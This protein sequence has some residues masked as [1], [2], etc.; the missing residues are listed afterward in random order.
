MKIITS[1]A[2]GLSIACGG[3]I[4]VPGAGDPTFSVAD[5]AL[6]PAFQVAA[7]RLAAATGVRAWDLRDT[8]SVPIESVEVPSPKH[9]TYIGYYTGSSIRIQTGLE[10]CLVAPVLLHEI[11]HAFGAGHVPQG[12]GLMAPHTEGCEARLTATDL[13]EFCMRAPC[14]HMT[15]EFTQ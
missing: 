2:C 15:P 8:L 1:V 12:A 14:T 9:P 13:L 10:P 3:S 6:A 7:E 4:S 11:M 5:P